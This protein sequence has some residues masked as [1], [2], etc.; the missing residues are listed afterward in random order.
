MSRFGEMQIVASP[1]PAS[2]EPE[3]TR[4]CQ[5]T[6]PGHGEASVHPTPLGYHRP[7][8]FH[9]RCAHRCGSVS[10]SVW[11]GQGCWNPLQPRPPS[12]PGSSHKT[13]TDIHRAPNPQPTWGP[14][15]DASAGTLA[16][17]PASWTRGPCGDPYPCSGG[18]GLG[19]LHCGG[20]GPGPASVQTQWDRTVCAVRQPPSSPRIR[21]SPVESHASF[22]TGCS[23]WLGWSLRSP[24]RQRV[25]LA[26][27]AFQ[28][29]C[30]LSS[31]AGEPH[32][33]E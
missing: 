27:R 9:Y 20:R 17:E 5:A 30:S 4:G 25:P 2:L 21:P 1:A 11:G 28:T 24:G 8:Q 14:T 3:R 23:Q 26:L 33:S 12:L 7:C 6:S 10:R 29:L 13:S 15:V 19:R 22:M 16:K 18:S 32:L 31:A